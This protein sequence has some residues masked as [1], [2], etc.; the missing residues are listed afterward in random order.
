MKSIFLL[1]F[2][3]ILVK[4]G[5]TQ[6]QLSN[7]DSKVEFKI[8]NLGFKVSGTFSGLDGSIHF[9]SQNPTEATFDVTVDA[10]S[11]STGIDMRDSHLRNDSYFDVKRYPRIRLMSTKIT[12]SNKKGVL[13][14]FGNLTIKNQTKAISF[15]FTAESQG[16]A[17][18]FQGAFKI[19]R[20]DFDIGGTSTISDELEVSLH[21]ITK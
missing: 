8:K 7:N 2:A 10:N 1:L 18:L 16:A 17:Y 9:D 14:F 5:L 11:V 6:L 15:P 4:P 13:F 20:K 3:I 19:N 21:V 12:N